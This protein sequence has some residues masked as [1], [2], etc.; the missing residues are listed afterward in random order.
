[1][2]TLRCHKSVMKAAI[3][4]RVG[5]RREDSGTES[6]YDFVSDPENTPT[7][8]PRGRT[9]GTSS[10]TA[11]AA[12][13]ATS[14]SS[15]A[16]NVAAASPASVGDSGCTTIAGEIASLIS[17]ESVLST[18]STTKSSSGGKGPLFN[19]AA[20]TR[21]LRDCVECPR[22]HSLFCRSHLTVDKN[23]KSPCPCEPCSGN[24]V[25]S[26]SNDRISTPAAADTAGKKSKTKSKMA[27]L[28]NQVANLAQSSR[29]SAAPA[30][31]VE[32]FQP[33]I[34]VQRMADVVP[35]QCDACGLALSW[36][37]LGAHMCHL[38]VVHCE[39]AR[40]GCTWTGER[41]Y[42]A[43]HMASS[44]CSGRVARVENELAE[45]RAELST[46]RAELIAARE[47]REM[48]ERR[49]VAAEIKNSKLEEACTE[50]LREKNEEAAK[51]TSAAA[52]LAS[53]MAELKKM[54]TATTSK[55]NP[56][57]RSSSSSLSLQ[58]ANLDQYQQLEQ[59][60]QQ[61]ADHEHS[62][63]AAAVLSVASGIFN[64]A[65]GDNAGAAAGGNNVSTSSDARQPP[66]QLSVAVAMTATPKALQQTTA[67]T[68]AAVGAVEAACQAP[69]PATEACLRP[70]LDRPDSLL[71]KKIVVFWPRSA[72]FVKCRSRGYL[73][74]C[75]SDM[76][77]VRWVNSPVA[78]IFATCRVVFRYPRF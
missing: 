78:V 55:S 43:G 47:E 5:L 9:A 46:V 58:Q 11:G 50:R 16:G 64:R 70:Y 14:V 60:Q 40:W 49:V 25:S 33:N 69:V 31:P 75:Q 36:G 54:S 22:C 20:C 21:L 37:E 66:Q 59:Q 4:A 6:D 63:A 10:T 19:C 30:H 62:A 1:M 45:A 53:A 23:G 2:I 51:A 57:G 42:R 24:G 48:L 35:S 71:E 52:A 8:S 28:A 74:C 65:T 26:S 12:S 29:A 18:T 72:E 27:A 32:A 7:S 73:V 38:Q 34:P 44:T 56:S 77:W 13:S 68:Q 61:E 17:G 3:N 39:D 76:G 67:G 41:G 15:E